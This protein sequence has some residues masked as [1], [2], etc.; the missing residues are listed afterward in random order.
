[1]EELTCVGS[2]GIMVGM[3]TEFEEGDQQ[4]ILSEEE[5]GKRAEEFDRELEELGF[6]EL[7][8]AAAQAI[9]EELQ[10][11][12]LSKEGAWQSVG[13]QDS[14]TVQREKGY[15]WHKLIGIKWYSYTDGLAKAKETG[16][17]VV[18]DFHADW[19]TYCKKMDK[20]TFTAPTVVK[21]MNEKFISISV[22]T[23]KDKATAQKYDIKSLPTMWFLESDGERIN[24]LPGF[25]DAAMFTTI[26]EYVSS[27]SFE[28]VEFQDY[29]KTK[30]EK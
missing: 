17:M 13:D 6:A 16:R 14:E 19:C 5:A 30:Q 10:H 9:A 23:E 24:S 7:V 28:T 18:I 4:V 1:M 2:F 12:G 11:M 3:P 15:L 22:D 21:L 20:E 25:V 26:L 29:L 27:R 8:K